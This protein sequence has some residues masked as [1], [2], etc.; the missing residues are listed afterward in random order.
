MT[1][2]LQTIRELY[3]LM[4]QGNIGK[5]VIAL[6]D[7]VW[8]YTAQCMGGNRQGREGILQQVPAFYRPGTGIKKVAEHFVEEGI[9]IIVLGNIH[10]SAPGADINAMPFVDVWRFENNNIQSVNFYY[11]DPEELYGYLEHYS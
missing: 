8:V 2:A 1:L 3:A 4:E 5:L 9:L 6:E 10:I 7:A 11:R